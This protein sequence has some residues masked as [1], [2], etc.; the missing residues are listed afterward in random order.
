MLFQNEQTLAQFVAAIR[1]SLSSCPNTNRSRSSTA[2]IAYQRKDNNKQ[3]VLVTST[4]HTF[5]FCLPVFVFIVVPHFHLSCVCRM[6][7]RKTTN[8][9]KQ[10]DRRHHR[11]RRGLP[12]AI[13]ETT[14]RRQPKTASECC[15]A[16]A[17]SNTPIGWN[18]VPTGTHTHTQ[19]GKQVN[20]Q[21]VRLLSFRLRV[22]VVVHSTCSC[23]P[24]L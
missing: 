3:T 9:A 6:G 14:P 17:Q 7:Q 10:H 5:R 24:C 20:K 18:G 15:W 1:C 21:N 12:S 2:F 19:T 23:V 13:G 8:I 16:T 11:R 4:L 22:S